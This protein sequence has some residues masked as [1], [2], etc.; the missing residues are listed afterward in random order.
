MRR[1]ALLSL[2]AV[3]LVLLGGCPGTLEIWGVN[4]PIPD[5]TGDDDDTADLDFSNYDG[6]EI[7]NI[8]WSPEEEADGHFD[9]RARWRAQ[10]ANTTA[11]DLNLCPDCVDGDQVWEVNL[12]AQPG[13]EECLN[14]GTGIDVPGQYARKLAFGLGDGVAFLVYRTAFSVQEPLGDSVNDPLAEAGVGAFLGTEF[15]WSGDSTPMV[16]E[17]LRYSFF[18][19]GEGQF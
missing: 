3:A 6:T 12:I 10:G 15:T 4:V 14:Q 16:N 8:D 7:L 5:G 2:L 13:A 1:L 11:S 9:C 17:Q 19:S 18:F